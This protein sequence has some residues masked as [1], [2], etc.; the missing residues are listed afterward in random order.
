M[1]NYRHRHLFLVVSIAIFAVLHLKADDAPPKDQPTYPLVEVKERSELSQYGITWKFA[2]P[3]MSGQFVNG[4]WWVVGPVTLVSVAPLPG[5]A[6]A[7]EQIGAAKSIYG[8]SGI[9]ADKQMRNGSMIVLGRDLVADKNG[10]GFGCQ[11]YDSRGLNYVPSLSMALPLNLEVNRSLISTISTETFDK[12]DKPS[13]PSVFAGFTPPRINC[14]GTDTSVLQGA[15]VLTCLDKAP[16]ADAFRPPY[17]GTDK[18]F[19]NSRI[20]SGIFFPS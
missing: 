4:D 14:A 17:V 10:T 12:S 1:R 8:A 13:C 11:G 7:D 16:P 6:P 2:Q 19:T 3:V 9:T 20:S 5:P 15:A 18:P